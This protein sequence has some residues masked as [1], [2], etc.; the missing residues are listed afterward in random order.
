MTPDETPLNGDASRG[1]KH[2]SRLC[3]ACH[4]FDSHST[5]P[6]L[7]GLLDRQIAR[8]VDFEYSKALTAQRGKHWTVGNLD[9]FI[10]SPTDFVPGIARDF[11]GVASAKERADII[12]F[13]RDKE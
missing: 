4:L 5:G 11:E 1:E 13:L 6:N 8:H 12:A 2:F 10:Q 3:A 7:R 9:A